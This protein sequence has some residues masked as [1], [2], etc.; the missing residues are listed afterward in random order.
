MLVRLRRDRSKISDEHQAG[1][2]PKDAMHRGGEA[3]IWARALR[4][5]FRAAPDGVPWMRST[6]QSQAY[7]ACPLRYVKWISKIRGLLRGSS[8]IF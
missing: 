1:E 8:R 7:V 4:S 2:G 3:A 5:I 6:L